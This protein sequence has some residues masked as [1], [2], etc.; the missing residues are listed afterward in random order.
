M[1]T[2]SLRSTRVLIDGSLRPAVVRVENGRIAALLPDGPA[3]QDLG[4]HALLPG[5]VDGHVHVN[6]PGRALWEGFASATRAAALGGVTT[7]VDMPLN[8]SP[9][10]TTQG[11]LIGKV[12]QTRGKLTVDVAFW[13]GVVPG[14]SQHLAPMVR[15]G[16]RGFKCFLCP[17]GLDEFPHVTAADLRVA[18]PI[19]RDCGVPLLFHAELE[20]ELARVPMDAD[21]QTYATYLHSRPKEWEERAIALVIDMVRQTGCRAHIVHL[22]AASALPQI[23]A[24][25][26]EGLP[27]SVET[28]PHYLGLTSAEVP[29][30]ATEWKCSPPIREDENRERLW[31]GLRDGVIDVVVTDH[32]PCAPGLKKL[33]TGDFMGAWGGI[34]S[35]QL[36]FAAVWTEAA[37][38]GFD[39]ATLSRWMGAAP[40]QLA[41][42]PGRGEIRVGGRA[43]LTAVAPEID[44]VVDPAELAHRHPQTPW[45]GRSLRGRVTDTWLGGVQI[46]ARGAL[47]G[48]TPGRAI[49][50]NA[51]EGV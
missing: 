24:A 30:G 45:A 13:G 49:L 23:R 41:R 37:R 6:E 12:A 10:T 2:A 4:D 51:N 15:Q 7:I 1:T 34:A 17:S 36:G 27:L 25:K 28:C 39:L 14:N 18:M 50:S 26:A 29:R 19:L 40:A 9:V 31:E 21:P 32:S 38:R 22:S 5:F 44:W 3:V 33:D 43:D 46:V 42:L 8:S 48:V 16:V 35:L 11:A 20:D 47:V